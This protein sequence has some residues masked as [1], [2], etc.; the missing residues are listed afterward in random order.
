MAR[1]VASLLRAFMEG[2]I[3]VRDSVVSGAFATTWT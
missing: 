2:G 3:R 1:S